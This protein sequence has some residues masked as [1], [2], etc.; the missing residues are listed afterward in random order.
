MIV[1]LERLSLGLPSDK[2]MDSKDVN[3]VIAN[4]TLN[5]NQ[6]QDNRQINV[7]RPNVKRLDKMQEVVNVLAESGVLEEVLKENN[8]NGNGKEDADKIIDVTE[9]ADA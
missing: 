4:Y 1:K 7:E 6:F 3:A 8:G 5:Q 9:E 2:P